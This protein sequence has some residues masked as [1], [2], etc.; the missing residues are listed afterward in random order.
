MVKIIVRERLSLINVLFLIAMEM[1]LLLVE[2]IIITEIVV[3][4]EQ[5]PVMTSTMKNIVTLLQKILQ[6]ILLQKLNQNFNQQ[7]YQNY[8]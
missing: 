8:S 3:Q 2:T 5:I 1:Q 7:I 4:V 6:K